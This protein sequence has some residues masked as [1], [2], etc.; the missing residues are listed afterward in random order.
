MSYDTFMI[1]DFTSYSDIFKNGISTAGTLNMIEESGMKIPRVLPCSNFKSVR[2]L[3]LCVPKTIL[4]LSQP[5]KGLER[6]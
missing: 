1:L 6:K 2:R 4:V 3:N 5:S